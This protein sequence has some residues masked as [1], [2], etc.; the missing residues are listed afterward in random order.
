V[1]KRLN[2]GGDP[3]HGSGYGSLIMDPDTDPYRDTG[4]TSLDGGIHCLSAS[5]CEYSNHFRFY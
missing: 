3:D 4:K 5:S 1:N 2:F